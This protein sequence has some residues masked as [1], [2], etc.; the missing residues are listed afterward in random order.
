MALGIVNLVQAS[1]IDNILELASRNKETFCRQGYSD[2]R[3]SIRSFEELKITN[4]KV[5]KAFLDDE[6]LSRVTIDKKQAVL[7]DLCDV[8]TKVLPK[9][10]EEECTHLRDMNLI[11]LYKG[12]KK[13]AHC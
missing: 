7:K 1:A 6:Y 10:F 5:A 3:P 9:K 8:I 11:E 2:V 4:A 12:A 13:I